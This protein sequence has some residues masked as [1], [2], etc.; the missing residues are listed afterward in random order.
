MNALIW[1]LRFRNPIY[2]PDHVRKVIGG[3]PFPSIVHRRSEVKC[4]RIFLAR[5]IRVPHNTSAD[6]NCHL[7]RFFKRI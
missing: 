5:G 7:R 4:A 3:P 6:P 1:P 2:V